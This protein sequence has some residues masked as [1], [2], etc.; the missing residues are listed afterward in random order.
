MELNLIESLIN[1]NLFYDS[2]LLSSD[3]AASFCVIPEKF[4]KSTLKEVEFSK[5]TTK[6][7]GKYD[8]LLRM[9]KSNSKLINNLIYI[10]IR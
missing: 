8:E 3:K 1:E 2:K 9:F 7:E 5:Q 10:T 6:V 4:S